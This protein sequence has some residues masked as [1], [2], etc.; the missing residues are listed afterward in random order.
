M[1]SACTRTCRTGP[2]SL[3]TQLR[4]GHIGLRGFLACIKV[5]PHFGS[6]PLHH[7]C[8]RLPHDRLFIYTRSRYTNQPVQSHELLRSSQRV[9]N[10]IHQHPCLHA[11]APVAFKGLPVRKSD[12]QLSHPCLHSQATAAF[13]GC[14]VGLGGGEH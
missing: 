4:T 2:T 6:P 10:G 9:S 5:E 14:G 13:I 7:L 3:L 1:C 12:G 8:I 11:Q